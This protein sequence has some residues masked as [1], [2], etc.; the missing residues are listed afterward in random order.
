MQRF[1]VLRITALLFLLVS[2]QWVLA[3]AVPDYQVDASW[4]KLL[5]NNWIIGQVA[6][7]DV[8]D[9]D[10]IWIVHRP[11]SLTAQ[12]AGAIQNPPISL[13]CVPAPS[14]LQFDQEGNLLQAWGSRYWDL[15]SSS[16]ADNSPN[17]ECLAGRQRRR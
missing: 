14:V 5:P 16:W 7:I 4:P 1:S 15:E 6:G 11:H 3:Q 10:N 9:D 17:G 13:C 2:P 12:E 8:D